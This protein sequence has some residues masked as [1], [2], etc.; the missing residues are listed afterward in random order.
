MIVPKLFQMDRSGTKIL[1]T[2]SKEVKTIQIWTD[3]FAHELYSPRLRSFY[4]WH[5]EQ[6]L[7][8]TGGSV[9]LS[10]IADV[11]RNTCSSH[12]ASWP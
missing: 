2:I 4:N 3:D 7:L 9:I 11:G 10:L 12:S 5:L 1:G 8:D 6:D